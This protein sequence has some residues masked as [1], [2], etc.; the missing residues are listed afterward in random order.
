[1]VRVDSLDR[2]LPIRS[3]VFPCSPAR[4]VP[5]EMLCHQAALPSAAKRCPQNGQLLYEVR[6]PL[7]RDESDDR[8]CCHA[9]SNGLV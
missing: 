1:M 8:D 6:R 9:H 7:S 2:L 5:D 3:W 4:V